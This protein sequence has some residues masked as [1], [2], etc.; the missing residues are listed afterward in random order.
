MLQSNRAQLLQSP[1]EAF[2]QL[3]DSEAHLPVLSLPK[4]KSKLRSKSDNNELLRV[5]NLL[6]AQAQAQASINEESDGSNSS[7]VSEASTSKDTYGSQ[8]QDAQDPFA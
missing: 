1:K 7:T 2:I 4:S 3:S 8:S 6:L 5:A